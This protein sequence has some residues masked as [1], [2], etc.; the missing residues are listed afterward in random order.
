MIFLPICVLCLF[1]DMY[2]FYLDFCFL[3]LP[4]Y[5]SFLP[6]SPRSCFFWQYSSF[7]QFH[8]SCEFFF[9]VHV[10]MCLFK[11]S[12]LV[13]DICYSFK[14]PGKRLSH[15]TIKMSQQRHTHYEN[16]L[17]LQNSVT[18]LGKI[19]PLSLWAIF[20]VF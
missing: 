7:C 11:A 5:L 13:N 16:L 3:Y 4:I 18:I 17:H 20:E 8:L 12:L 15:N 14:S 2:A 1:V 19:L 6:I 9:F 10:Y